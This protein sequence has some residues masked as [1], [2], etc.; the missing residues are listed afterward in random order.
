MPAI[1]AKTKRSGAGGST[2]H[3]PLCTHEIIPGVGDVLQ[4]VVNPGPARCDQFYDFMPLSAKSDAEFEGSIYDNSSGGSPTSEIKA[5]EPNGVLELTLAST[6]EAE[7]VSWSWGDQLLIPLNRRFFMQVG[8]LVNTLPSTAERIVIG[9]SGAR[10]TADPPVLDDF[11]LNIWARLDAGASLLL[12]GDDGTTNT[13]DQDSGIDLAADT[14]Y[15]LTIDGRDK[16]RVKF[17]LNGRYA[18]RIDIGEVSASNVAQ[19]YIAVEKDSGAGQPSLYVDF[20][21]VSWDRYAA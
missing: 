20:V 18:G 5:D 6:D 8:F 15:V 17:Y 11:A 12:E 7:H 13:D 2:L 19:P 10:D 9:L 4:E 1:D 21:R 3:A 14:H 16:N